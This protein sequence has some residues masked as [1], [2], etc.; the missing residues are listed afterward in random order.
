MLDGLDDAVRRSDIIAD[1]EAASAARIKAQNAD[2]LELDFGIDPD[3]AP[4]LFDPSKTARQVPPPGNVARN[5]GDTTAIKLGNSKGDP[6]PLITDAMRE[7]GLM[8]GDTSRGAVMGVSE[9]A[10]EMGRFD[11]LVD[12]FRYSQKEMNDAAWGIYQDILQ[13]E[14]IDEVRA[15]FLDN[16]DV[17]NMLMGRFKVESINEEQARAAAFALRDLTDRFLGREV[18]EASARAMNTTGRES[19]SLAQAVQEM[20]PFID[21]LRAMNLILDKMLF[22]M[23]EL[24]LIHI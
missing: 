18:T 4:D 11:I 22:L 14:N 7:K 15:L 5:M 19:A 13:A 16:R 12:G 6:A 21:D 10:R 1:N 2:Q 23:D 8:V 3:L 24:S 9:V 17:K 20:D